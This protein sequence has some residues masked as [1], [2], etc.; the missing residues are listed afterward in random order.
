METRP[1]LHLYIVHNHLAQCAS[2][3]L[4][5]SSLL[6]YLPSLPPSIPPSLPLSLP[7]SLPPS[8]LQDTSYMFV[9]GPKVV[10]VSS[11]LH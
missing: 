9:T 5:L 3:S 8:F 7:L 2:P 1:E 11:S 4:H 6:P 10:E